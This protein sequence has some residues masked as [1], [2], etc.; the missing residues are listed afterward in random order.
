[1]KTQSKSTSSFVAIAAILIIVILGALGFLVWKSL[2]TTPPTISQDTSNP[3]SLTGRID[4]KFPSKLSWS[5][6]EAWTST[7]EQSGKFD[8]SEVTTQKVTLTSPNKKY[9]V[10][11][12]V[13][14]NGGLGGVCLPSADMIQSIRREPVP[15]LE[16]SVFAELIHGSDAEGYEY[17]S[18]LFM[19]DDAMSTAAQ[20]DSICKISMG[21][22]IQLNK[23]GTLDILDASIHIKQFEAP[24]E[25]G[26]I[27]VTA[28]DSAA[29][30]QAFEDPEYKAAIKIL[31]STVSKN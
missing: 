15:G 19:N 29:I 22:V 28:K 17:M 2:Q 21:N 13:A 4:A 3:S 14:W 25:Y 10:V 11:Y 9:E 18:G 7:S 31:L 6:P 24:G 30:T 26:P 5:Y 12:S 16:K 20:G 23:D 8:L 1:M 27:K